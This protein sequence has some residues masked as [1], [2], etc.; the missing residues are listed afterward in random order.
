M[1]FARLTADY[2]GVFVGNFGRA[3]SL[4]WLFTIVVLRSLNHASH[5]NRWHVE[6]LFF[7]AVL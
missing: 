2:E 4:H 7:S 3:F 6:I 5:D 1:I